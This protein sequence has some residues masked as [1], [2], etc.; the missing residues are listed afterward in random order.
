MT[1]IWGEGKNLLARMFSLTYLGDYTS[2][3]LAILYGIDPSPVQ[4]ITQLKNRLAEA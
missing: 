1:E 4:L 3:Y 2:V